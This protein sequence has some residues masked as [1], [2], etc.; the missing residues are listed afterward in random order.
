MF[1]VK[2]LLYYL[3]LVVL[4]ITFPHLGYFSNFQNG[5]QNN[6]YILYGITGFTVHYLCIFIANVSPLNIILEGLI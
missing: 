5:V 3:L 4:E 1:T 6:S 2:S